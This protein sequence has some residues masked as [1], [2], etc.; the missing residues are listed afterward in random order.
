MNH[1]PPRGRLGGKH[2]EKNDVAGVTGLERKAPYTINAIAIRSC[3]PGRFISLLGIMNG[4][5]TQP[6]V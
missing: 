4:A 6:F 3:P 5:S 2:L 1:R